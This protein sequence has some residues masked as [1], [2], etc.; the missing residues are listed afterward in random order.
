MVRQEKPFIVMLLEVETSE[1][2]QNEGQSLSN[3]HT[4]PEDLS[5]A[6]Q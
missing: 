5:R 2:D 1:G 6:I 3:L 4:R